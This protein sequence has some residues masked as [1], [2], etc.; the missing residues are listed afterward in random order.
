MQGVGP[1]VK[2]LGGVAQ[3]FDSYSHSPTFRS[4]L[5]LTSDP[6]RK[7]AYTVKWVYYIYVKRMEDYQIGLIC[8][9]SQPPLSDYGTPEPS[10]DLDSQMPGLQRN[11]W[12]PK[13][14]SLIKLN[15]IEQNMVYPPPWIHTFI[16]WLNNSWYHVRRKLT[17]VGKALIGMIPPG[18][19]TLE[20]NMSE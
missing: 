18:K 19:K 7:P 20:K 11:W 8:I 12:Q 13:A 9:V 1:L 5:V 16:I 10:L 3:K 2:A 6:A 17:T 14:R 15:L 4:P